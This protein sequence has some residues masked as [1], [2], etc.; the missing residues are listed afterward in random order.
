MDRHMPDTPL[1]PHP[2]LALIRNA[3]ADSLHRDLAI[4]NHAVRSE[5]GPLLPAGLPRQEKRKPSLPASRK[6]PIDEPPPQETDNV[7]LKHLT[8][9]TAIAV[10]GLSACRQENAVGTDQPPL[11]AP[12]RSEQIA[13]TTTSDMQAVATLLASEKGSDWEAYS[14][15]RE[16]SWIDPSP[17]ETIKGRY[18]RSGKILLKGLSV[19]D[20]PNGRPGTEYT[21]AKKNEGE[22][23]ISISGSLSGV[24]SVSISKPLYSDDYLGILK[25]QF[26]ASHVSIIADKCPAPDYQEGAGDGA[27][28][29]AVLADKRP[30]FIQA[31]QQDGG[32]YTGGFTVFDLTR[33]RPSEAIAAM[34]CSRVK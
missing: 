13:Q 9:A 34:N 20:I 18:S 5:L 22:S 15:L 6:H 10:L 32:K 27:F 11:S 26:G 24:E 8:A 1:N 21:T 7:R 14:S 19:K 12:P 29:E 16:V 28:F 2:G 3:Y 31:S 30:V 25:N 23:T 17:Q 33:A 4:I